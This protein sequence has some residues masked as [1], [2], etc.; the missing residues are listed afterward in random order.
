MSK[1][2]SHSFATPDL[3][4]SPETQNLLGKD[5]YEK[6]SRLV[7]RYCLSKRW[8]RLRKIKTGMQAW[9]GSQPI[10]TARAE[11]SKFYGA[12]LRGFLS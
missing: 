12:G 4:L 2:T 11:K 10:S 8:L 9:L 1:S 7:R 3:S 5:T 6:Q